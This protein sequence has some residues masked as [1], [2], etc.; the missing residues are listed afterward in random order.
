MIE[1]L[2]EFATNH[3]LLVAAFVAVLILFLINESRRG[4]PAVSIHEATQL[5]NKQQA[6][7][8]DLRSN[9]EFKAGHIN[10]AVNLP[11]T[12]LASR[13]SELDKY[14]GRPLILVCKM[15]Q[16]SKAASRNLAKAGFEVKRLSGGMVDWT[17]A[18]LP[19]VKG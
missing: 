8:L 12:S 7:V 15:G 6:V 18:N 16:H 3:Y 4:A 1:Q 17:S 2:I 10:E 14:Q 19:L 13:I 11:Y 9:A 5:I